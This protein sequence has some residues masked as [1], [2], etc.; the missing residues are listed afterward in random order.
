MHWEYSGRKLSP[1]FRKALAYYGKSN[2]P[3]SDEPWLNVLEEQFGDR[4]AAKHFLDAYNVSGR[5]IPE[6]SALVWD[7][8]GFPRGELHLPYALMA[9]DIFQWSWNVSPVRTEPLQPIW[10][11]AAW[12]AKHPHIFRDQNG[13]DWKTPHG[14]PMDYHQGVLW[15]TQG[16]SSY[17]TIPPVH[18]AKLRTMGETC[19]ADAEKGLELVKKNREEAVQVV[20]FMKA[21]KLLSAYYEKKVN[22]AT[23]GTIYFYSRKDQDKAD[24][25]KLADETVASYIEAAT[26]MQQELNPIL[27]S[28]YGL[29]MQEMKGAYLGEGLA[30][31]PTLIE[32]EKKEREQFAELFFEG[33]NRYSDNFVG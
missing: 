28:F 18:M 27:T 2:E 23:L 32:A 33:K 1:L 8:V 21:Y 7:P 11:Y 26:F 20:K 12:A 19:L 15:R 31:L 10:H 5:I 17:D 24:A 4:R 6:K 16:G 9:G 29:P 25:L 30:D 13:S 14:S 3:Y 22:A